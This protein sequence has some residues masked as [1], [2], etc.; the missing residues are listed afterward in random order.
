MKNILITG[1]AGFLG[2]HLAKYHLDRGDVVLGVDN[3]SSSTR[4]SKHLESLLAKKRYGDDSFVFYEADITNAEQLVAII[5]RFKKKYDYIDLVYNFAC[6]ASPPRYQEIPIETM[7]TCTVGVS[8][9]L[10]IAS[11]HSAIVVHASTSEVYGDPDVS[12]QIEEYRGCVN[13]YG[14]RACYDEGKRSAESLCFDYYNKYKVDARLVRIFNTYGPHMDA[15]DGRVVSNF[16]R[17][18]LKGEDM[19]IYGEG[20]QTRSFCYVDDLIKAIV[21]MG[22]LPAN[23]GTPIN[24]GN[25]EEYSV[26]TLAEKIKEKIDSASKLVKLPL[27]TDDPLQ[28]CPDI[29]KAIEVL[30]W[31]PTTM[32]DEGLDKT[33]EYFKKII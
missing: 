21:S 3:F 27:P 25:P 19:T 2:S 15:Y 7:L 10:K 12:P 6:P 5:D 9:V 1:V 26:A 13:S 24:I 11:E 20:E 31:R 17:Q 23:P 8:N 14:P 22:S 30:D 28:R 16:I 4:H 18:C 32:L 33:I 29:S